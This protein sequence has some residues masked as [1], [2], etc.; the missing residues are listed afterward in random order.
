MEA[1]FQMLNR[2]IFTNRAM[3]QA[4]HF[5]LIPDKQ[6]AERQSDGQDGA[7][8]KQLFADIS[9]QARAAIGILS[10]DAGN[11]YDCIAHAFASL[12]F[13]AF[14]VFNTMVS[15]MLVTIQNM[16]FFLRTGFGESTVFMTA[17]LGAIIH[18]LCQGNTAS[19]AGWS[20]I[21]SILLAAYKRMGHGAIVQC[22][23]SQS[24]ESTAGVLYVDEVDLLVMNLHLAAPKLWQEAV[25]CAM[26]WSL[27][28]HGPGGTAVGEKCF[29]YL[30][31]YEWNPD[32]SWEYSVP[33]GIELAVCNSDG[34]VET[35][36]LLGAEDAR[37]TL[38][39]A[40]TPSGNNWHHLH[41][42]GKP[43]DK[44]RSVQSKPKHWLCR[45]RNC[46]LPACYWDLIIVVR[47]GQNSFL[48]RAANSLNS[49]V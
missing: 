39:I 30:L 36:A 8:L 19:P 29:G 14:G 40:T 20:L 31:D 38:G 13:Q 27:V 48:V 7:W 33:E 5:G 26:D 28:L 44:W 24:K 37:V 25:D 17:V 34:T 21:S 10:A 4:R 23:I 42:P 3:A 45:L 12:V 46:H 2:L 15:A 11:C 35:I 43:S 18:G 16:K 49:A 47:V 41:A 1:D 22:P 9:R 32:G 6:Y